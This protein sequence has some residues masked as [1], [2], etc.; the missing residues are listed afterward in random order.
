MFSR[1]SSGGPDNS[2]ISILGIVGSGKTVYL[3]MLYHSCTNPD[4]FHD[5]IHKLVK[6]VAKPL[7][8][9]DILIEYQKKIEE[10]RFPPK[11]LPGRYVGEEMGTNENEIIRN[12]RKFQISMEIRPTVEEYSRIVPAIQLTTYDLPGEYLVKLYDDP[13]AKSEAV[14][15]AMVND[16][17]KRS[18]KFIFTID[19]RPESEGLQQRVLFFILDDIFKIKK[20]QY[21]EEKLKKESPVKIAFALT[22]MDMFPNQFN[23]PYEFC[24]SLIWQPLQYAVLYFG[25]N[26]VRTFSTSA[27]GGH[28]IKIVRDGVTGKE[29]RVITPPANLKPKGLLQPIFWLMDINLPVDEMEDITGSL[30]DD[31]ISNNP[32]PNKEKKEFDRR[33]GFIDFDEDIE[34]L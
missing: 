26:S 6:P 12:I 4:L 28:D 2:F 16:C 22:K 8:G 9:K 30:S 17:F 32:P 21:G 29:R 1:R 7:K 24:E 20:E 19:P 25:K 33:K 5:P 10:G 3:S 14:I 13:N 27:T 18:N 11:T 31:T 23:A 34:E 15:D